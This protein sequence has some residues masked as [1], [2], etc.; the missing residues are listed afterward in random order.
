MTTPPGWYPDERQAGTGRNIERW[1]DGTSWTEYT[2]SAEPQPAGQPQAGGQAL[3]GGQPQPG[4]GA[5]APFGGP[6]AT[7]YPP[8]QPPPAKNRLPLVL[9]LGAAGVIV[10]AG[11]V[12]ALV[13]TGDDGNSTGGQHA[14]RPSAAA[15]PSAPGRDGQGGAA[16]GDAGGGQESGGQDGGQNGD[17]GDPPGV[18]V[19]HSAGISLPIPDGWQRQDTQNTGNAYIATH[20]YT[21]DTTPSKSCVSAG[22]Y[23]SPGT[24]SSAKD[25]AEKDIAANAHASYGALKGHKQTGAGKVTVAGQPGYMIRWKLDVAQGADGTVESVAFKSPVTGKM[26]IVRFGID[27]TPQ[28]PKLTII[29]TILKGIRAYGPTN[30]V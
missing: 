26:T 23:T 14:T 22:V 24:G 5:P 16:G 2:R 7:G 13:V 15:K 6:A 9:A 17:P 20:P 30:G 18:A 25:A 19:D 28:A 4:F 1:W 11:V 27:N 10:V 12:V 8:Y 21:C 29:S 3:P